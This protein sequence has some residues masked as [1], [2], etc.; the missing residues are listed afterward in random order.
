MPFALVTIGLIMVI[1][2]AKD[3]Y[4]QFGNQI[5]GDFT[6]Q[7]NFTYWIASLGAIGAAGYIPQLRDF[8]RLF[9]GLIIL[10]IVLANGKGFFAK[11][12][13]ALNKGPIAPAAPES[14]SDAASHDTTRAGQTPD[15]SLAGL[16]AALMA[17]V[18]G[19]L[20]PDT[21]VG[22]QTRDENKAAND[23]NEPRSIGTIIRDL[24]GL[25]TPS[26]AY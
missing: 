8:S 17:K 10:V 14:V 25:F 23:R 11:L 5:A 12:Q 13:E 3:T 18:H 1:T 2:G 16:H 26:P 21:D 15:T 22:V 20:R 6:G 19:Y 9:M 4:A 24:L 7:G